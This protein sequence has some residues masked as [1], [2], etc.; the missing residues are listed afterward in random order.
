MQVPFLEK[1]G[2]ILTVVQSLWSTEAALLRA[3]LRESKSAAVSG[4]LA[5]IVALIL[6]I[7][8]LPLVALA[9]IYWL[10]L[11]GLAIHIATTVVAVA[12]CLIAIISTVIA[13]S[14][15]RQIKMIPDK[16]I[17]QIKK[18]FDLL[19]NSFHG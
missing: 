8:A 10:V 5:G 16:T 6:W 18:D 13:I 3:E 17:G 19:G 4:M 12:T 11:A 1:L 2:T 7:V 14:K 15:F 9:A